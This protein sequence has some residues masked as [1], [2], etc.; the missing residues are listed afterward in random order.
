MNQ[1][2]NI[3]LSA[4]LAEYKHIRS[5]LRESSVEILDRAVRFYIELKGDME[6]NRISFG[7][8]DDYKSWLLSGRSP[9]TANTYLAM[10]K[11][12]FGWLAKRRY[13]EFSPFDG[14][15]FYK[16]VEKKFDIFTI[17]EVGRLLSIA[18]ELW[19]LIICLALCGMRESEILNLVVRDIDFDNKRIKITPKKDTAVTWRWDIKD[20]HEAYIGFDESI[21]KL[22]I[23][24]V[25]QLQEMPYVCIKKA[26]WLRNLKLK[27]QGRLRQRKRNN[28]WGNFNRDFRALQRR[29]MVR[30]KRFHDL[31]GTFTT[32]RYNAGYD[33][34]ELQY[35]LRHSAISTTV[36][37]IKNIDEVHLVAKSGEYFAKHYA[38]YNVP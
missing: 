3:N 26:Y 27:S 13:I 28:P 37:Y 11:S 8:I 20:Y 34:R 15:V 36:R 14:I 9:R 19:K 35:L 24:R 6:I 31:R 25:E 1:P 12:F 21:S 32:D 10:L 33:L 23:A 30:T 4:K 38:T 29:A 16:V 18:G 2:V 17:D 7:H 22:L 5:D